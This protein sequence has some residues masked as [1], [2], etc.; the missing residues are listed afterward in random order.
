MGFA[1]QEVVT[2]WIR[3]MVPPRGGFAVCPPVMTDRFATAAVM[4]TDFRGRN[5]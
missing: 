3:R 5:E 1:L 2:F 4:A